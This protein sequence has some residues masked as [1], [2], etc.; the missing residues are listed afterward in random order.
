MIDLTPLDVRKKRGDFKKMLRGY[1]PQEVDTF[2]ELVAERLEVLVKESMSLKER[3]DLLTEQVQVQQGREKAIQEA[4]VTAQTLREDISQQA[5]R[6]AEAIREQ[7]KREAEMVKRQAEAE[8]RQMR[9]QVDA[10][11]AQLRQQAVGDTELLRK[12]TEGELE[13]LTHE[14]EGLIEDK[15]GVIDELERKRTRFLRAFRS[16]L[17]RELD[18]VAIE[19]GKVASEDS[20][21]ELDLTGG[22]RRVQ[23]RMIETAA[24]DMLQDETTGGQADPV[25]EVEAERPPEAEAAESDHRDVEEEDIGA[26][27]APAELQASGTSQVEEE[28]QT[29][30][31][32]TPSME[33]PGEAELDQ[34]VDAVL[35]DDSHRATDDTAEE[36]AGRDA[37]GATEDLSLAATEAAAVAS[38]V[39]A[40]PIAPEPAPS[41]GEALV[42]QAFTILDEAPKPTEAVEQAASEPTAQDGTSMVEGLLSG[43]SPEEGADEVISIHTLAPESTEP[44]DDEARAAVNE[45][46]D[47]SDVPV[48][49]PEGSSEDVEDAWSKVLRGEDGESE[50]SESAEKGSWSP[51]FPDKGRKGEGSGWT[52]SKDSSRWR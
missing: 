44:F 39:R 25:P 15:T 17:E 5:A 40:E 18:A 48:A 41:Q 32:V 11:V 46:F 45:L 13:R 33:M 20:I 28:V 36:A 29:P 8:A 31:A 43:D 35:V 49:P 16:L 7:A 38:E 24:L 1:D 3:T 10:E 30:A 22:Q 47:R 12:Q 37:A 52:R 19:E 42:D 51:N 14:L 23:A 2:L 6:E 9:E 50:D 26:D 34:A 4:L 27:A 21:L